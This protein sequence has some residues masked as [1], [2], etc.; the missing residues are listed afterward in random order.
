MNLT[1][2]AKE[3]ARIQEFAWLHAA[4]FKN[5]IVKNTRKIDKHC[6]FEDQGDFQPLGKFQQNLTKGE[7]RAHDFR[8]HSK[9]HYTPKEAYLEKE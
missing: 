2:V 5:S 3:L 1:G 7:K 8:E 4:E 9:A 6:P